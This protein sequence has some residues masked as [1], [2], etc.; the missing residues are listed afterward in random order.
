M[1]LKAITGNIFK[2]CK[3]IFYIYTYIIESNKRPSEICFDVLEL[4][5]LLCARI[6]MKYSRYKYS[7]TDWSTIFLFYFITVDK[8]GI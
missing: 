8:V 7:R 5:I 4:Y 2:V 6:K 1:F 3:L